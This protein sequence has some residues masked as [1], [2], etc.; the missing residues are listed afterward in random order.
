MGGGGGDE[1]GRR[2]LGGQSI[3]SGRR[4]SYGSQENERRSVVAYGVYR[5][6]SRK[7]IVNEWELLEYYTPP[8]TSPYTPISEAINDKRLLS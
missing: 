6:I 2:I 7:L 8:P 1:G 3:F 5:K 4:G